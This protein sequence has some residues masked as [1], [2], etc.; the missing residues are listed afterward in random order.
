[1]S[2]QVVWLQNGPRLPWVGLK[3]RTWVFSRFMPTLK[4]DLGDLLFLL[5]W[6]LVY[7]RA[8]TKKTF[9]LRVCCFKPW[10]DIFYDVVCLRMYALTPVMPW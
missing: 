3:T 1:M 8:V 2:S 4:N 10:L 6:H 9:G 5:V 7:G